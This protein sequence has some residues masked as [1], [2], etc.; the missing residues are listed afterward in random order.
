MKRALPLL[1]VLLASATLADPG[2]YRVEVIIFRNLAVNAEPGLI[3]ELRSYSQFPDLVEP[4]ILVEPADLMEPEL[5]EQEPAGETDATAP[6]SAVELEAA[7]PQPVVLRPDLPDGLRVLGEKSR[8]MDDAW[9]RLRGSQGYRPLLYAG[10]EQNRIDYYPPIRVHDQ[11][12]IA[13]RLQPPTS[14]ILADLTADDPLAAYR[15]AF[16]RLDGSVQ[17]RRTRFLHLYLDLEYRETG[18]WLSP[19]PTALGSLFDTQ[20]GTA[21][22]DYTVF[23]LKQSRQVRTGRL[24]YFDTPQFGALVLVTAIAPEPQLEAGFTGGQ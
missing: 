10:W 17:L 19:A 6:G 20:A 15:S 21:G 12:V 16:Y 2:T 3:G 14:A 4:V 8:A 1:F 13:T 23:T 18:P 22:G 24:Q 5:R 7:A 11:E 9:R